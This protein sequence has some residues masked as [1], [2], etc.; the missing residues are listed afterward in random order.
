MEQ[1]TTPRRNNQTRIY[2]VWLYSTN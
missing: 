1:Y 2:F